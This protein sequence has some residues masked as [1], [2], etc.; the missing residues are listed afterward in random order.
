MKR[1]SSF[2]AL[3]IL[4][5]TIAGQ[6]ALAQST[7]FTYQGRLLD[8]SLPPTAN[9]DFEFRLFD[10]LVGGTQL[11][12]TQ[13]L[14]GVA[15]SNGIFT[16]RLDFGSQF[17]G[18]PRFLQ[19]SV[20]NAPG[21]FTVLAPRQPFSSAP[22][23]IKS[24]NATNADTAT[25]ANNA[26][27]L[28]GQTAAFYQNATNINAGTLD[29]ARL[30]VPFTLVGT[31]GTHII[32]GENA[33]TDSGSSGVSGVASAKT[34]PTIG[35]TGESSST[36]GRGVFGDAT[37]PLGV[38]YGVYGRS[39]SFNGGAGVFGEGYHIGVRGY[40][41]VANGYAG[42][43]TGQIGSRNYF[44]HDVGIGTPQPK[45]R[46]HVNGTGWFSGDT[47]PLSGSAGAGVGIGMTGT[48]G[49]LFG[50]DY[51]ASTP[52]NMTINLPGGNVGIGVAPSD[53]LHVGGIIRVDTL[54]AAGSTQLCRNASNQIAT[55]SSS[56]KYKTNVARFSQGLSFVNRLNPIS[57]DW[58]DGG[59]KDVGFGAED[60]AKIDPRFVTFNAAGEVEGVKYDRLSVAF[61]NA[62]KEQ[63]TEISELRA[64][65]S[66][67][68]EKI[69]DQ[70]S[71]IEAQQ[72]QLDALK[73]L[74]CSQNPAA[75]VCKEEK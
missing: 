19:I 72:K 62:L 7:E 49:Y 56:L 54:G 41:A 38:T 13:Q 21:P 32:R 4:L 29:A 42:Y 25:T 23:A 67:Q 66:E 31:S 65:S 36:D 24:L 50:F 52:R 73:K 59:M 61:V 71:K 6:S 46:L 5:I 14:L 75:E 39:T 34:G 48:S 15:V 27:Q 9:Y 18:A 37:A 68:A 17:P 44:E 45:S 69:K 20:K 74:V 64:V 28:N 57:Y 22:Y 11:G 26:T 8:S 60:I 70:S 3:S 47:T 16:V 33:S 55:C 51:A 1:L 40:T 63:Q 12:A 43:F 53:K 10:S 35:V 2:I 58:K 30:P